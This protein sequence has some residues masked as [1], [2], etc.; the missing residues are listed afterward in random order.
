M[1]TFPGSPKLLKGGLVLVDAD[2]G[3]VQR[4]ISLQYNPDS[5][6]RT[7][8]VQAAGGEGRRP[9]RSRCASR[10]RRSRRSSSTPR[11]T[12]PTS[13]SFPIRIRD[14]VE[15]GIQP[16][17]AVLESLVIRPAAQL[18]ARSTP[19]PARARWRSRRCRRRSPLFVWSKSRIVPV[20]VTDFSH[21]RGGLRPGAQP[22]PRQ[23]EPRPARAVDRRPRLLAQGR[24]PVHELSADQGAAGRPRRRPAASPHSASEASADGPGPGLPA[25]QRARRRRLFPPRSRYYGIADRAA[26]RRPTAR[27]VVFCGAAS[28]RRRRISRCCSEHVVAAGDRSTIWP[29]SYLGDPQQY[30]R[31]CDANGA[32]QPG[33]ADRDGRAA[34]CASPCPKACRERAMLAKGIQLTLLIGPIIP[35]PGAAGRDGRA[36]QRRGDDGRRLRRAASS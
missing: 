31:I 26:R 8:Q 24:Q 12:P 27:T 14:A 6:T 34:R 10:D 28:C 15:F 22:D 25:G 1:T 17:L 36:R 7:L 4:I 30:W 16:Q 23:G 29:R 13:S 32:M 11:S 5:L 9:R 35:D 2:T 18:L 33:G 19:T 21:H 20:R 3:Q